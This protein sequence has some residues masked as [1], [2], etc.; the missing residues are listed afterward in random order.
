L[1][2]TFYRDAAAWVHQLRETYEAF[3][4]GTPQFRLGLWRNVFSAPSYQTLFEPA[5]ETQWSFNLQT[6]EDKVIDRIFS[7]SYIAILPANEKEQVKSSVK[8]IVE[9]G[10]GKVWVNESAG[11]FEY[12]YQTFAV[13]IRRKH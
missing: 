6:T 13:V 11:V 4:Q 10:E 7:K 9:R 12:P 3:E 1:S 8:S 2:K 5:E